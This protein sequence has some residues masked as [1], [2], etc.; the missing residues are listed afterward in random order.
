MS[1]AMMQDRYRSAEDRLAALG[2]RI[3]AVHDGARSDREKVSCNVERH[4]DAVRAK[5]ARVRTELRRMAE[6]DEA[7]WNA[8]LDELDRELDELD[9]QV[10]VMESQIE[11]S[12]AEDWA[13]FER[14]IEAELAAD[15]RLLE[16]TRERVARAKDE[17]RR[18]A[19]EAVAHVRDAAKEVGEALKSRRAEAAHGWKA[20]RDEIR[21]EMD[22]YDAAVVD[23]IAGIEADL[24]DERSHREH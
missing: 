2:R 19:N 21:A 9:A 16:A 10:A 15:D 22:A 5:D 7:A 20:K 13:A 8:Y 14:A 11:A 6:E 4:L 12:M 23:A 18:R 3:D 17:V 24:F 1:T